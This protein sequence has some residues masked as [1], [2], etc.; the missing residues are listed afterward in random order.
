MLHRWVARKRESQERKAADHARRERERVDFLRVTFRAWT[1]KLKEARLRDI[2][3]PR[4]RPVKALG[5]HSLLLTS[6]C[7]A[8]PPPL[9]A[10][11]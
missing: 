8:T 1:D 2:V 6:T 4:E 9:P 10:G 7:A 11:V 3:R 5:Q